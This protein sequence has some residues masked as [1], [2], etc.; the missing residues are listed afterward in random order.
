MERKA[1]DRAVPLLYAILIIASA[2]FFRVALAGIAI[3]GALV[4]A[5]YYSAIRPFIRRLQNQRDDPDRPDPH[6]FE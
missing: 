6:R 1:L 4:V 3:I 2:M 5:G